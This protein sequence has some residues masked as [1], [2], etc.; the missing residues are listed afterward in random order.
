MTDIYF[1]IIFFLIYWP[2]TALKNKTSFNHIQPLQVFDY[3]YFWIIPRMLFY[4]KRDYFSR[5]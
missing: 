2:V 1:L 3:H 4:C 5:P